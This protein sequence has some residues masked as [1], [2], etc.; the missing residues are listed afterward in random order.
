MTFSIN[1]KLSLID[2]FQFLS[3]SLDSLVKN[4]NKDNFKYLS[5][6][7]YNNLLDWVKQKVFYPYEYMSGF[8]KF[9]ETKLNQK[10]SVIFYDL[11]N[12]DSHLIIQKLDK[13]NL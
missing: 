10:N 6:E 4:L 8:E 1:N 9:K 11:K 12:Y 13:F 2:I 7:F 3:S 5:Q